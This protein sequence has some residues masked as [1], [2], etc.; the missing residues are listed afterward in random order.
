MLSKLFHNLTVYSNHFELDNGIIIHND[1]ETLLGFSINI[2]LLIHYDQLNLSFYYF[3]FV[4]FLNIKLTDISLTDPDK[5]PHMVRPMNK[6]MIDFINTSCLSEI[7]RSSNQFF[8][9][10]VSTYK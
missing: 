5:Y 9:L 6:V 1:S 2:F 10:V 4:Q 3:I 8:G 7:C